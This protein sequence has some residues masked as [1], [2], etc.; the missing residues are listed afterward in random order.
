MNKRV[1]LLA[2]ILLGLALANPI[3]AHTPYSKPVKYREFYENGK[4]KVKGKL[5]D[6]QK[7]GQW[8]YYAP[9]QL[10]Q[11]R[12]RYKKGKLKQTFIYNEKGLLITIIMED[13]RIIPQKACGCG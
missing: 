12:E 1:F 2:V 10:L 13:G 6:G 8:Y 5:V 11:K 7:H 3:S 4:L 9:N